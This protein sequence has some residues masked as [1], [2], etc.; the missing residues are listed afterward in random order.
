MKDMIKNFFK[1]NQTEEKSEEERFKELLWVP[2]EIE[3]QHQP[4]GLRFRSSL[5]NP[6]TL[7]EIIHNLFSID[8]NN[9]SAL[10]INDG[11]V[12]MIEDKEQIWKYELLGLYKNLP[13]NKDESHCLG[14]CN[15]LD[16][17]VLMLSFNTKELDSTKDKFFAKGNELLIIHLQ[18][19]IGCNEDV[20]YIQATFCI[21]ALYIRFKK[22]SEFLQQPTAFSL[23]LAF[24][25]R[26]SETL[27][28]EFNEIYDNFEE[29][30]VKNGDVEN[31]SEVERAILFTMEDRH[32]AQEFWIADSYMKEK[33]F[34]NA[35]RCYKNICEI[36]QK[37]WWNKEGELTDFEI[38]FLAESAFRLSCCYHE[39]KDFDKALKWVYLSRTLSDNYTY[40]QEFIN[41][42]T[43]LKDIRLDVVVRANIDR[44]NEKEQLDETDNTFLQFLLRRH[45]YN[46]VEFNRLDEAENLAKKILEDYPDSEFFSNE[47][48]YIQQQ[49][50][51]NKE[52]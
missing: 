48:K 9:V 37:K 17:I 11:A 49:K 35:T 10:T 40:E 1:K 36:M 25:V 34:Y 14:C 31:L 18:R 42:L 15:L 2:Q 32:L 41:N 3:F 28:K 7:G 21:P 43:A 46:M 19:G 24:N 38:E 4:K 8:K 33:A 44:M 50:M 16:N 20:M 12:Q 27:S 22:D 51:Q 26:D 30:A 45:F 52:A 23:L 39:I 6:L 29:K 13:Y 5:E 47:L